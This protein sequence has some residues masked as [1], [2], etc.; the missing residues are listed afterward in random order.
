M[1]TIV[2]DSLAQAI[3]TVCKD[4]GVARDELVYTSGRVDVVALR[5]VFKEARAKIHTVGVSAD[6]YVAIKSLCGRH[7]FDDG[8][9]IGPSSVK[10]TKIEHFDND[11]NVIGVKQVL[12]A[13]M[14][15]YHVKLIPSEGQP[16]SFYAVL[17]TP[18]EQQVERPK[19]D[20]VRPKK[21]ATRPPMRPP[22]RGGSVVIKDPA[23][24]EVGRD[25]HH[26]KPNRRPKGA[27]SGFE[28]RQNRNDNRWK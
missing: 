27:K 6:V 8:N 14:D 13:G 16:T 1:N 22:V 5:A 25:N 23:V 4:I 11:R 2:S 18:S 17:G 24:L 19:V 20:G 7:M 3:D 9:Y 15:F 10:L 28:R 12:P 21:E 26:E